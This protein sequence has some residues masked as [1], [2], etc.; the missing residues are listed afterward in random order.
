MTKFNWVGLG[1]AGLAISG[2]VGVGCGDSAS[3][4]APE[5]DYEV[6]AGNV[7]PTGSFS[8][9]HLLDDDA[10]AVVC[11]PDSSLAPEIYRL[12]ELS[13]TGE[14]IYAGPSDQL[15]VLAV[16]GNIMYMSLGLT[17]TQTGDDEMPG[18]QALRLDAGAVTPSTIVRATSHGVSG[19]AVSQTHVYWSYGVVVPF[20]GTSTW[21]LA[22]APLSGGAEEEI[23][24]LPMSPKQLALLGDDMY[25]LGH[26]SDAA[27]YN[28]SLAHISLSTHEAQVIFSEPKGDPDESKMWL[29]VYQDRVVFADGTGVPAKLYE[30]HGATVQLAASAT[31]IP[32][33]NSVVTGDVV[34]SR[35]KT[36]C[37]SPRY[38]APV[39]INLNTGD[40]EYS[41][42]GGGD[43]IGWREGWIYLSHFRS[44]IDIAR[45]R[46]KPFIK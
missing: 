1:L 3:T 12:D 23:A 4:P 39:T 2:A 36:S 25:A 28:I 6:V 37:I 32:S 21:S 46:M 44:S 29:G 22:R 34:A 17:Q 45:V 40:V 27:D 14:R 10:I 42:Y 31:C 16:V 8:D 30:I 26:S 19:F 38:S 24:V 20:S 5:P 9:A 43:V 13:H 35:D 41:Q 18:V 11:R 15:Q 33:L 7:C